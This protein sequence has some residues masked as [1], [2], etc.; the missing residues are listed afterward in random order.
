MLQ[1]RLLDF[2]TNVG[3]FCISQDLKKGFCNF[4]LSVW[5]CLDTI[6]FERVCKAKLNLKVIFTV[7]T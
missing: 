2:Y 1:I 5:M 4:C 3:M 7:S 6:T